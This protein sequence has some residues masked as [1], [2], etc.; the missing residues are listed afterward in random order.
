MIDF[1][2]CGISL[3]DGA[4]KVRLFTDPGEDNAETPM[5]GLGQDSTQVSFIFSCAHQYWFPLKSKLGMK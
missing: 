3:S 4:V 5:V 2:G 1:V